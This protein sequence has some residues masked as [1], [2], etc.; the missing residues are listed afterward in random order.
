MC[1]VID[2]FVLVPRGEAAER[3]NGTMTLS[4]TAAFIY[5]HLEEAIK[6]RDKKA[7]TVNEQDNPLGYEKES[8]LLVGFA[9]PCII[10]MLVT[11]LYNIVD[12]IFI[13]Q[14]V[15]MLGNAATN[16]AFPLSTSCTA[17]SLL[18]GIGSATNF[19]LKL[20]AGEEKESAEYAGNGICL[21]MSKLILADGSPRYSM[22]SM[23]VGA[24][25]NTILDPIFIFGLQMGMRGAALA[26][27]IGQIVSFCISLRYMFH[28]KTI[29]LTKESFHMTGR[30]IENIFKFGA[31]ACF[32]QIAMTIV[33]I[34]LNNTLSHYG[35]QS[36]Y[37]GDIPL[38]CAGIITKVNMIF[39]SFVIGI[40]QGIQPIIG[41]NYGAEK[42]ERVRKSYLLALG[43]A[44]VLS[45]IAFFC[46]QVFPR[47][48][49]SVFG[50]GS[51]LYFQFSERYFRIYM[52]L[53]LIN[54][55]Q[56]VT[57]NFFNSIG[58]SQLGVFMSLTRQI[59]FLLPLIVIFPLFMGIDGVMYAG[60]IA[61]AAAAIVCGYFMVR[62][63]K[64]LS[65]MD[66]KKKEESAALS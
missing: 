22:T 61:D 4:E 18:L 54:G 46:F 42:Y 47:Q 33:Q 60:P 57:S 29:R 24:I 12:Q 10:S 8:K 38:A 35:A 11:A 48:I 31:S 34:V 14:G 43:T 7:N 44:T 3:I 5:E 37:G 55:I 41:F 27:I 65:V 2:E 52:F 15:G 62:E 13:G 16:I 20:G 28:F 64:E 1:Q 56:P 6:V 9:I 32:N 19:S 26:T 36:V 49:I 30:H 40:S 21:G 63:L 50:S 45:G 25:V 53:T 66:K 39:M 59:L 51:E 23:L 17:I 58:K